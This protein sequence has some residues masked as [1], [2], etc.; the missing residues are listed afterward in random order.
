MHLNGIEIHIR[1]QNQLV[2]E[3]GCQPPSSSSLKTRVDVSLELGLC[4]KVINF[5]WGLIAIPYYHQCDTYFA[6]RSIEQV[7]P[8]NPKENVPAISELCLERNG[9]RIQVFLFKNNLFNHKALEDCW[10]YLQVQ[11]VNDRVNDKQIF[12]NTGEKVGE[13]FSCKAT[14]KITKFDITCINIGFNKVKS[15]PKND[16]KFPLLTKGGNYWYHGTTQKHAESIRNNGIILQE[17]RPKQD[18]SHTGGFYLNPRFSDAAE[19]ASRRFS[20]T[21]GAVLIYKLALDDFDGLDLFSDLKKWQE[22]VAYYRSG[23]KRLIDKYLIERCNQVDF[24]VGQM[25]GDGYDPENE[26][27]KPERKSDKSQLCI[28]SKHMAKQFSLSL[29]GII[30][31]GDLK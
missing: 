4:Q 13:W 11:C 7:A 24:I 25:S 29:K 21:E 16:A 5:T 20:V 22:I 18:F 31:F 26:S 28:R 9:L 14:Q 27:W 30:Y 12:V 1:N 15:F 6:K 19:W 17:G 2:I 3:E 10:V 23:C 8:L